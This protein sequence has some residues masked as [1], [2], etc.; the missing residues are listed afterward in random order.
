[1]SHWFSPVLQLTDRRAAVEGVYRPPRRDP[2]AQ[3]RKLPM[4]AGSTG[5][6]L[7]PGQQPD[8]CGTNRRF[9]EVR[10]LDHEVV[11]AEIAQPK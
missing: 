4:H 9:R 7:T 5:L 2:I 8:E 10:L 3:E 6:C 1:M 11:Y